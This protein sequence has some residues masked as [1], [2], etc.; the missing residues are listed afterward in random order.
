MQVERRRSPIGPQR[1]IQPRR[2]SSE[3]PVPS[4]RQ[5]RERPVPSRRPIQI[6]RPIDLLQKS[7]SILEI[8]CVNL[9]SSALYLRLTE[10]AKI[11]A[12]GIIQSRRQSSQRLVG[13]R[14]QSSEGPIPSR[15]RVRT[16]FSRLK[17]RNI[18]CLI[19]VAIAFFWLVTMPFRILR[20]QE[21]PLILPP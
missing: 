1:P 18:L 4:R 10:R 7:L 15:R 9:R 12:R 20:P 17:Y 5:S 2:Q 21:P 8:I 11:Y 13:P 6:R 16:K 3:R 19:V 14:R